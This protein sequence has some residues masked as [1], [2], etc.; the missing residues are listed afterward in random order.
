MKRRILALCL[1][2]SLLLAACGE[3]ESAETPAPV[4]AATAQPAVPTPRPAP[5]PAPTPEPLN[6]SFPYDYSEVL[7][8]NEAIALS[9]IALGVDEAGDWV[10]H[11]R[12]VNRC[13]EI[14]N[15]RFLYQSINGLAIDDTLTFRVAVGGTQEASFLILRE[16]MAAWGFEAPVQWS[17]TL[18]V[19]SAESD[20][21][22]VF[23]EELSAAP[24]GPEKAVRYEFIPAGPDL[25][26]MDNDYAVVYIT[27]WAVED[28]T[29]NIEYVAVSRW[30]KPLLLVLPEEQLLL[31]GRARSLTLADG[32]GAYATLMG[33]IP[34]E[35]WRGEAPEILE[36]RLALADPTDPEGELLPDSEAIAVC[37]R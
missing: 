8:D 25:V 36:L 9:V 10:V 12:M 5:T 15:F 31:D 20:S 28:G 16:E 24:F 14:M 26:V 17:F 30:P 34:V 4:P 18:Q 22:P 33:V 37:T 2:L 23:E 6:E 29:L 27:G 1:G 32:F 11:L 3:T 7:A 13:R 35:R 19:V 21:E